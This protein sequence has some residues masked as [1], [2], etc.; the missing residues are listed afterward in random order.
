MQGAAAAAAPV[1][2]NVIPRSAL[3]YGAQRADGSPAARVIGLAL[4]LGVPVAGGA[5]DLG[6]GGLLDGRFQETAHM[7]KNSP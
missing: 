6:C 7:A 3:I 1:L 4:S 2:L 5:I